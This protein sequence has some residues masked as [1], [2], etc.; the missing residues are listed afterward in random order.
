MSLFAGCGYNRKSRPQ[1]FHHEML[2]STRTHRAQRL[3]FCFP[4]SY[5]SLIL[6]GIWLP[7]VQ[8]L[9]LTFATTGGGWIESEL[10]TSLWS[11]NDSSHGVEHIRSKYANRFFTTPPSTSFCPFPVLQ[12]M[13]FSSLKSPLTKAP[14][15]KPE[16]HL[17]LPLV[18][19]LSIAR[20]RFPLWR[21]SL[22]TRNTCFCC[23]CRRNR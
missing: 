10:A 9:I 8:P 3:D 11:W 16:Q 4:A 2:G 14:Q 22:T 21:Y 23:Q 19:R 15:E 18:S 17:I 6:H 13:Y 7:I 1:V 12:P 5:F 20:L